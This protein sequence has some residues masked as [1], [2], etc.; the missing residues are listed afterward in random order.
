MEFEPGNSVLRCVNIRQTDRQTDGRTD[1]RTESLLKSH[2][3][4]LTAYIHDKKIL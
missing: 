3:L 2:F 4:H 1:G